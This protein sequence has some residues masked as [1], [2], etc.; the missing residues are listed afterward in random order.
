MSSIKGIGHLLTKNNNGGVGGLEFQGLLGTFFLQAVLL[1][2]L[3]L[4]S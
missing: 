3:A 4:D 2:D 1:G